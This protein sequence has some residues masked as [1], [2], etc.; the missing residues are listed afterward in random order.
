MFACSDEDLMEDLMNKTIAEFLTIYP[1]LIQ[2]GVYYKMRHQVASRSE[3]SSNQFKENFTI[4]YADFVK[5]QLSLGRLSADDPKMAREFDQ[6]VDVASQSFKYAFHEA[7]RSWMLE[8]IQRTLKRI[9]DDRSKAGQGSASQITNDDALFENVY[10]LFCERTIV[11]AGVREFESVQ[12]PGPLDVD[13]GDY[14]YLSSS[15][16]SSSSGSY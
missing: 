7:N 13:D 5:E 9:Q 2:L 14:S 11:H 15:S 3:Y 16:G 4:F 12:S 8:Y 6:Y 1:G 10:K